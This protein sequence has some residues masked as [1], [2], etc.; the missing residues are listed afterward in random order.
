MQGFVYERLP[1]RVIFGHGTFRRLPE[2]VA[3]LG[4][5]R[6][7]VLATPQQAQEAERLAATL[8][9]RCVGTF[10]GARMH[11]PVEVTAEAL[12]TVTARQADGLIAIGGGSTT[13]LA[14]AIAL[15]TDLPQIVVP[16][17]YAGSEMT[18]ILGETT[19]G[20]KTTQRSLKVL[21][22]VVIYDVDLTLTLPAGLSGTSGIN[23]I[24]HAVEALY[25]RDGDP[26]TAL[27]AEEGIRALARALPKIAGDPLDRA[28]RGD[29]LYGAFLCG[30]CLGAVGM[31]L[32]HKLCHILGGAFDL[33]HAQTHAIVLPHALAY[34]AA[35]V[36]QA[37]ARIERALGGVD[38]PRRLHDLAGAVAAPRALRD[39]GMPEAGIAR[40]ADLA[41]ANPSWNPV[42]LERD[43]IERLIR[44]AWEGLP[45]A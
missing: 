26:I 36:P 29:A 8:A 22:E 4:L 23:A 41:L 27:M 44:R 9:G 15:R 7:L 43:G 24:A 3:G 31:A 17:T 30:A 14:K 18:P 25:A 40:V 11:T 37:V 5:E 1:A 20:R 2:E 38:A 13:G 42:P 21:P 6:A 33:P 45:P 19:D 16:T 10:A 28:A 12:E 32:H 34:N 39:V 35:A